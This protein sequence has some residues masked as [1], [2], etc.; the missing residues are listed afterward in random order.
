MTTPL[1]LGVS[2]QPRWP[3]DDGAS[4]LRVAR[5]AEELGFDHVAVGNRLLDSGF[6]LDTDPLVPPGIPQAISAPGRPLGGDSPS[7]ASAADELGQLAEA[8]LAACTLWLPIAAEHVERVT[9]WIAA[10]VAP[11]L[12]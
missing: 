4:V 10:E 9:E 3:V 11:Q 7:A 8:G 2:L 6:G 5:H 12:G 1:R